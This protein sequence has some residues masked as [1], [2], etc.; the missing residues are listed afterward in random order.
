MNATRHIISS[1]DLITPHEEIRAGFLKLALEKN[2][3]ATPYVE[4][5][6]ALRNLASRVISPQELRAQRDI[7][8]ALLTAAGISDKALQHL[9]DE[10]AEEIITKL[11]ET[12]LEP[13]GKDFVDELVFRFLLTRGDSLGGRMRN[14]G[15]QMAQHQFVRALV[16][17]LSVKDTP[18]QWLDSKMNLW[19]DGTKDDPTIEL[20]AKGVRWKVRHELRILLF[21][22]KVPWV[23]KNVDLSLLN[24]P[25]VGPNKRMM[26]GALRDLESYIALG[27][28]KGGIDPAGAD[29]HWKTA[30]SALARIRNAAQLAGFKPHLFLIVAAIA[31]AMADEIFNQ[32]EAGN[33]SFA[34]NITNQNQLYD[35]CDWLVNL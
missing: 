3:L 20:Q 24:I 29:E 9:N 34:A 21:N 27:E 1:T 32:L 25:D 8:P 19:V 2:R 6:K 14:L 31:K 11:I 26:A 15:G 28:L 30:N 23:D 12:F 5:A 33:L 35:L 4:Q 18:F 16:A 22:V 17:I 7:R 10:I 13:A